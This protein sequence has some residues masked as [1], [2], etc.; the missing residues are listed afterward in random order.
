MGYVINIWIIGG[1]GGGG[2]GGGDGVIGGCRFIIMKLGV[3]R[4]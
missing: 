4:C 3:I 2:G 1:G